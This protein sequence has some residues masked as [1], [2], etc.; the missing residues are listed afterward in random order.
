M[1][2]AMQRLSGQKLINVHIN[3]LTGATSFDFDLGGNLKVRRFESDSNEEL[4][5]L[6]KPKGYVLTV[7]GDGHYSH[8]LGS[9]N[10]KQEKW[11]TISKWVK[12]HSKSSIPCLTIPIGTYLPAV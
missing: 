6:Y 7:R 10:P 1:N 4:W 3:T 8:A 2:M 5:L 9:I 12:N 11:H